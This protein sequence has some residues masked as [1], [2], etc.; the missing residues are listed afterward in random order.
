MVSQKKFNKIQRK[1]YYWK[2][3]IASTMYYA[4]YWKNRCIELRGYLIIM[5]KQLERLSTQTIPNHLYRTD[6]IIFQKHLKKLADSI[7][8][9][10]KK[11]VKNNK[12]K[13]N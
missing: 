6:Y 2:T 8:I 1:Y 12:T 13:S 4:N 10:S 3:R 9:G 7:K 5:K 11:N